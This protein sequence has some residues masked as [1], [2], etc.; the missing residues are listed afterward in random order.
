MTIKQY[1]QDHK[2]QGTVTITELISGDKPVVRVAETWFHPQGGGQKADRGLIG[3]S[4]VIHVAHNGGEVD[5]YVDTLS[6]LEVGCEY[7]FAIDEPWRRL[8]MTYHSAGH[9]L[10]AVVESNSPGLT[11]VSGHQWPG[12]A[13]VEFEGVIPDD[14]ISIDYLNTLLAD[15][16]SKNMVV[17]IVGDPFTNRGIKIGDFKEIPCGGTHVKSLSE[18]EAVRVTNIKK[19]SGR[20]RINYEVTPTS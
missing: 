20:L 7:P 10:A 1:L 11:A 19:K 4:H 14:S 17:Q 6:G 8:N 3:T 12:E 5:H 16:I 18:I 15:A 9:L 2:T 13:R